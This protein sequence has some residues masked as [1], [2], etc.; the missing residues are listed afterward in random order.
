MK[1][2]DLSPV[3]LNKRL[4]N[5][6]LFFRIGPFSIKLRSNLTDFASILH[7]LYADYPLTVDDFAD[8]HIKLYSPNGVRRWWRP[9]VRFSL[10]GEQPFAPF[11]R[12]TALPFLEW[13]LNWSVATRTHYY[14][15]LHAGVVEKN[16]A[17]IVLP[18]LPGSGK[19]TLCAALIHRGWR[20]LSDEFALV[21]PSD[22]ALV[23]QP[24]LIPLKNESI[25]IIRTFAANAVLGPEFHKT[26]KGTVAHLRPPSNSVERAHE[27]AKARW[28]VFPA[29]Q[30]GVECRLVPLDKEWAFMKLSH[31]S[32]N[33]ELL[34]LKGFEMVSELIDTCATYRL[35]LSDLDQA[36]RCLDELVSA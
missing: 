2:A 36:V 24:R 28:I 1:L 17:A 25:A 29:Y 7:R 11:P 20:L 6:G 4:H 14:L 19:S 23:P 35:E 30:S 21:R 31:N 13:G 16:N 22:L 18:A 8:F 3:D 27:I 33:Y 9:Q 26:R 15:M 5:S 34:G 12:D 10:D 32:F